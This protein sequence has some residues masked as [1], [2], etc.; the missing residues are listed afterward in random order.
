MGFP[1]LANIDE[2]IVKTIKSKTGNN[3][4]ASKVMPWIR[5]ISSLDNFLI[6][7]SIGTAVSFA[8]QYGNTTKSGRVGVDKDGKSIFTEGTSRGFRPSPT[9][10]S[11]S[12]SQG[13]EGLSKKSSFQIIAYSL[14]Q[15]EMIMEY[16][17]EPGN[18][19][20]VEWGENKDEAISQ[21]ADPVTACELLRYNNLAY[22]QKKRTDSNG[23]YD[24]VLGTITGGNLSYG[25]SETFNIDVELTSIGELPAYLQHHKGFEL[26]N[27]DAK[28]S[29]SFK[30]LGDIKKTFPP[31]G[32][33]LFQQM[34]NKLPSSK[35]IQ[36]IKDWATKPAWKWVL[37]SSNYVNMDEEIRAE[38]IKEVE[39]VD[40]FS[41]SETEEGGETLTIPTETPLFSDKSYI[42]VALAFSI[43]DEQSGITP[44][45]L[46]VPA[47]KGVQKIKSTINWHNTICRAHKNMFSAN[48]DFL[49]IPNAHAPSFDLIGA[50][51]SKNVFDSPLSDIN[52]TS[53]QLKNIKDIH[54]LSY[55]VGDSA[56]S[57]TGQKTNHFPNL[58]NLKYSDQ[59]KYDDTYAELEANAGEWGYLRDL[60]INFDFFC[61]TLEVSLHNTKDV[62]YTLLN[63]MSS[64]VNM[65]WDFQ[66]VPRGTVPTPSSGCEDDGFYKYLNTLKIVED[67]EGQEELQIVDTNFTGRIKTG[68]S[69]IGKTR[70][71]SRGTKSPFLSAELKFDIP[72][73]M[74]GQIIGRKLSADGESDNVNKEQKEADFKGL[75]TNKK[76]K[77]SQLRDDFQK[78]SEKAAEGK[79]KDPADTNDDGKVGIQ[80]RKDYNKKL[81]EEEEEKK[82]EQRKANYEYFI[83]NATIVPS[84][85]SRHQDIDVARGV[86]DKVKSIGG[87]LAKSGDDTFIE[88]LMVVGAWDDANLLKKVQLM[89]EGR[90]NGSFADN[91]SS[92]PP[93]LPIKFNFTIHGVSGLRVG[94]TFV[95][96]DLPLDYKNKLFQITQVGHEIGTNLWSTTVE[97]QLRNLNIEFEE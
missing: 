41:K 37:D 25:D 27:S 84:R 14:E 91:T 59:K 92:N 61:K 8:Q 85:Q 89:N 23:L 75:F 52:S 32:E 34:Y 6:L 15:A 64:A 16:F 67:C 90:F 53:T 39:D 76:D 33:M 47:C 83:G 9:I 69:G 36:S 51:T 21:K 80:E 63:G 5:L 94:D 10:S 70:F 55:E 43:L 12:I 24:A 97:G 66:I 79:V 86:W 11:I 77:V 13:N 31:V 71:Q 56:D 88:D 4:K 74:K 40:L 44:T 73:A 20:L 17:I 93:L 30:A 96:N 95:I 35:R 26:N 57:G 78:S 65:Y 28:S 42:R 54:P 68:K 81:K 45:P 46:A 22:I 62:Y 3:V 49:Y 38:L 2:N 7:E 18:H 60:Y 58:T 72:A 29:L 19:V 48:S 82:E 1:Q 87:L 50:L